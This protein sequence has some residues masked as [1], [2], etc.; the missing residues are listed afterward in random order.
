MLEWTFHLVLNMLLMH[1]DHNVYFTFITHKL[2]TISSKVCYLGTGPYTNANLLLCQYEAGLAYCWYASCTTYQLQTS[3][4][5]CVPYHPIW[6]G[7]TNLDFKI[8]SGDKLKV[9]QK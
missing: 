2:T 5:W 1:K 9:E 3:M 8:K 7:T 6:Y 4:V